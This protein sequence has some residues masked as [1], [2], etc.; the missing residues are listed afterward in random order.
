MP[1][2]GVNFPRTADG[3]RS[4]TL[5][6][7][8]ILAEAARGVDN[9][10]AGEVLEQSDW[11]FTYPKWFGRLLLAE[12]ASTEA[13]LQVA[14]QGLAAARER[15]VT[16]DA[17]GADHP[18]A[19]ALD[20]DGR[21]PLRTV[22]VT[23][24]DER[25]REFIVPYRGKHLRG[26]ALLRQLD[27]WL[28]RG[29]VEPSLADALGAVVR[30]PDWLDLR[31]RTIAMIGAGS[32]MGPCLQ[33]L[34]WGAT[35]A[36]VDLPRPP[37]WTRLLEAASSSGGRMLVPVP[38]ASPV[39]TGLDAAG[40]AGADLLMDTGLLTDWLTGIEGPLTLGNYGYADGAGFVRL[41]VAFDVLFTELAARRSDLSANYLATP[42]DA[43]LVPIRAVDMAMRRHD[44]ASPIVNAGKAIH[45]A[46]RGRWFKPNYTE[47]A[48]V[49]TAN[50]RFGFLD[51]FILVQ[52]PNYALAKRLQ[53]WRMMV[54]RADGILTSVHVA[55]PTRT[56]SVSS[57]PLM[58]ER[59]L[60]ANYMGVET[61]DPATTEAL[62][63]GIL[64]HDL[65]N[66]ASPAN[67]TTPLGHPHEAFMFAAN[68]G[69][70]WR[71]PFDIAS[72]VPLLTELHHVRLRAA[73]LVDKVTERLPLSERMSSQLD[74]LPRPKWLRLED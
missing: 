41:S 66:P 1:E 48:I 69:G 10:F 36:A 64:V 47:E 29:I 12:A 58:L 20:T 71:V 2:F 52:G 65:R 31:D 54:A 19:E 74:R 73:G 25:V 42:A 44:H 5:T 46:S 3:A 55:P 53:R 9:A 33:L 61:F 28:H 26:V 11:R 49:E 13:S 50:E 14:R 51:A 70:R 37:V 21:D 39:A 6:G 23:G 59:D 68:P 17:S 16:V 27:E 35:V 4:S 56:R 24:H 72:S 67:P 45:A 7:Q 43:F 30:N 34:G 60:M 15:F 8:A 22:E 62:A 57:N 32:E 63:G 18:V 40:H 38:S